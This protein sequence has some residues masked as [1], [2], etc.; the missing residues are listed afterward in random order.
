MEQQMSDELNGQGG[1]VNQ[2]HNFSSI[3]KRL[4]ALE[5]KNRPVDVSETMIEKL[6]DL[7]N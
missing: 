7:E 2:E 4:D 3:C 1:V 5:M 6:T